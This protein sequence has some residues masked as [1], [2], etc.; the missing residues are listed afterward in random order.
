MD[1]ING[2]EVN[3]SV[4]FLLKIKDNGTEKETKFWNHA[5]SSYTPAIRDTI[6]S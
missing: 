4:H 3:L 6:I 1:N 2:I 5:W